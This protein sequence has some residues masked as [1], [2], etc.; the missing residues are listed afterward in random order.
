MSSAFACDPEAEGAAHD[1]G[2]DR[3]RLWLTVGE[4]RAQGVVDLA[5][6]V[7]LEARDSP[8]APAP[9]RRVEKLKEPEAVAT[10]YGAGLVAMSFIGRSQGAPQPHL[11]S[12]SSPHRAWGSA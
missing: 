12:L 10:A 5:G 4:V 6:D 7:A 11:L 2:S 8:L 1:G 3:W 9:A